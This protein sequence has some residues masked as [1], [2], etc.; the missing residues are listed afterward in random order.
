MSSFVHPQIKEY[1]RTY[2]LKDH[3]IISSESE[4]KFKHPT[5]LGRAFLITNFTFEIKNQ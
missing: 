1:M 5:K 4:W 3:H 2:A